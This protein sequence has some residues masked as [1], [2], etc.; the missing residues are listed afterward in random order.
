MS[1][2]F[3]TAGDVRSSR[4]WVYLSRRWRGPLGLSPKSLR[5]VKDGIPKSARCALSTAGHKVWKVKKQKNPNW[6]RNSNVLTM[7]ATYIWN[8]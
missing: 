2:P 6:K 5:G 1:N 8:G 7:K 3:L 4:W